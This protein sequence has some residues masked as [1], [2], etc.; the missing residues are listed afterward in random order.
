MDFDE[1]FFKGKEGAESI[2]KF[3]FFFYVFY[4][5]TSNEIFWYLVGNITKA[6]L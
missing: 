5:G 2:S 6:L 1:V 3:I 4:Y